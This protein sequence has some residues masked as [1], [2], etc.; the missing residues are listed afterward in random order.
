MF[1]VFEAGVNYRQ[2]TGEGFELARRISHTPPC[3]GLS[4]WLPPSV[5]TNSSRGVAE[6]L[7]LFARGMLTDSHFPGADVTCEQTESAR[8]CRQAVGAR[9]GGVLR[10]GAEGVDAR[11]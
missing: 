4:H 5:T 2:V 10:G 8:R 11:Q 3:S 6:L 9:W 1:Y 7:L